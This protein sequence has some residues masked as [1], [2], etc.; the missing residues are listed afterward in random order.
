MFTGLFRRFFQLTDG[1]DEHLDPRYL[2]A[3][4]L[5]LDLQAAMAAHESWKIR[6][7][8]YLSGYHAEP[9]RP[10]EICFD[11]RCELGHWIHG[12][13]RRT[14]GHLPAFTRLVEDHKTFHH[15][16]ANVLSLHQAGLFDDARRMRNGSYRSASRGVMLALETMKH[17]VEQDMRPPA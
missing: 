7:E 8:G 13:G 9:M 14:L 12:G 3:V 16:A 17:V 6:L 15:A 4:N 2:Q 5:S 11:D 1:P 10:E